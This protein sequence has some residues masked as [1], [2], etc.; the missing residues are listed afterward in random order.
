MKLS[1][2]GADLTK[3]STQPGCGA[4][5]DRKAGSLRVL[6]HP[7]VAEPAVILPKS[8]AIGMIGA[9]RFRFR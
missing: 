8:G 2:N 5:G 4:S 6:Q 9:P 1:P 7:L 3:P